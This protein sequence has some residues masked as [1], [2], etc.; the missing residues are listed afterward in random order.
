MNNII[1]ITINGETKQYSYG[2]SGIELSKYY[3]NLFTNDILAMKINGRVSTLDTKILKNSSV[4]FIDYMNRDGN[5]IYVNG[6]KFLLIIAIKEVL[7]NIADVNFENSIDKGIFCRIVN[8][9]IIN[10]KTYNLIINKM[11]EIVELDLPFKNISVKVKD[12]I[13]FY[14]S[15]N[16]TEKLKNLE[17]LTDNYASLTKCKSHYGYFYG[18]LPLST[19]YLKKFDITFLEN[20]TLVLRF[21]VVRG[22]GNIPE[23]QHHEKVINVFEQY[24]KWIN[25]MKVS[26]VGSL[27]EI[28]YKGNI[29]NFIRMNEIVQNNDL[30][31]I[32]ESISNNINNIKLV[33][34]AGPSSSGKTT[35]ANKFCLYLKSKG[36]NPHILSTDDYFYNRVDTPKDENGEYDFETINAID[37]ELFNTQ[38][39]DL[40]AGNEVDI[41]RFNF[42]K[43]E[44]EFGVRKLKLE[45]NDILIIEGLHTLN[46][47]LTASISKDNKIKIYISPFTPLSIDNYN[48]ISTSDIRLLRRIVRDNRT[49]G[50]NVEETLMSWDKVRRGEE[51]YVFPYQ[52]EADYIFNTAFI[53]EI[54]VLKVY[55]EPLLYAINSDSKYYGEARRL[56]RFLKIFLP[57]PADSVPQDSILREFIGKSCFYE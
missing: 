2:I 20:N 42:V 44:K 55:V 7:G 28:V 53:Y 38:L 26:N 49:R 29:A 57:I 34:I 14:K 46:E 3:K 8:H 16:Q 51:I 30:M 18:K 33:L 15:T 21:P 24:S 19:G 11:N 6:L 54:G 31:N 56:I 39:T 17:I 35:T 48:H 41:P 1:N 36:L 47:K 10:D 32:C 5:R 43:G 50:R 23:Y 9:P 12:L 52:D 4:E 13:E 22:D 40:I 45:K 37:L 27:N 25:I